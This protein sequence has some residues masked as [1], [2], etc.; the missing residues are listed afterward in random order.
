MQHDGLVLLGA[1]VAIVVIYN[2]IG[3]TRR[4]RLAIDVFKLRMPLF[5]N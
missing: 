1:V 2:F 3:R 4:G 5:G